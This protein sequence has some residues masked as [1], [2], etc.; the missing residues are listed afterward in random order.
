MKIRLLP[1]LLGGILV[2]NGCSAVTGTGSTEET[3]DTMVTYQALPLPDLSVSIPDGYQETASQFY[4][5]FYIKD[6]ATIIITEDNESGAVT[7]R[8]YSIN[9]LTQYQN[10][11]HSLEM[12][13]DTVLTDGTMPVQILEF[14][15]TLE[16]DS[17]PMSTMISYMT[18]SQTMYIITCKCNADTYAS[19]RDEFFAVI[20]SQHPDKDW[21]G[22]AERAGETYP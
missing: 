5:K 8:N 7:P 11:T 13:G 18:D 1:L 17:S 6:D 15:Y 2:L 3:H 14:T 4:E 22:A 16:E 21:V 19:H 20:K 10:M 12:L 9:A